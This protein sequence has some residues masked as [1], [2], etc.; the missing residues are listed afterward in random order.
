MLVKNIAQFFDTP[1]YVWRIDAENDFN[2]KE[3]KIGSN[4]FVFLYHRGR[5]LPNF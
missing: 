2:K 1:P 3:P 5:C 4:F